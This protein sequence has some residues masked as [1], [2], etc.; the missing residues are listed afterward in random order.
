MPRH[1][2]LQLEIAIRKEARPELDSTAPSRPGGGGAST[3]QGRP[4]SIFQNALQRGNVLAAV[5]AARELPQLSLGDALE[6]PVL[7]ARKNP[8]R[9]YAL[10][11]AGSCAC[12]SRSTTSSI[13]PERASAKL[14]SVAMTRKPHFSRTRCDAA[15]S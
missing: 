14:R 12:S 10:R 11:R 3:S 5:A 2:R 15:L 8:D 4:Y 1:S 9:H 6:R 7:I 13:S